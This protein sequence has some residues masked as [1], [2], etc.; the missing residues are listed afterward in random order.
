MP[1]I[2]EQARQTLIAAGQAGVSE[3]LRRGGQVIASTPQGQA[4]IKEELAQRAITAAQPIARYWPL[5][6]LAL[7]VYMLSRRR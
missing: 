1:S 7:G 4:A 3:V 2:L 6:L 5:A